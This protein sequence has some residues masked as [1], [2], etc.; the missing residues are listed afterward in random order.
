MQLKKCLKKRYILSLFVFLLL[1]F[2]NIFT[3]G[4]FLIDEKQSNKL[5]KNSNN[6]LDQNGKNNE[7]YDGN[8]IGSWGK[9]KNYSDGNIF[10]QINQGRNSKTGSFM[11][12]WNSLND[13]SSGT[14]TGFFRNH[15]LIGKIQNNN[16]EKP[17]CFIGIINLYENDFKAVILGLKIG[18]VYVSGEHKTSF[19]PPLTGP[20][21]VGVKSIHLIDESRLEEFTPDNPNDFREV[22][23]Q[24]WY[25]IDKEI[26][27]PRADYMD[28]PTFAWLK[29]KSPIPLF[30]IPNNAYLF[31]RPH[32]KIQVPISTNE[33]MY[34]VIIF[35][36]GY[37][38]V[39][40]IYTSLIEDIVSNG[41]IIASINHPYVSGITVFPDGRKIYISPDPP[42][43]YSLRSI[44]E[45]A[46]FI[47]DKITEMNN[48]DPDFQGKFDLSKVGMYGHSYGGASTSICCY[49]DERFLC[50]LTLDGVFYFDYLQ[51]GINKP[52]LML[53]AENRFNDDSVKKMWNKLNNDA[54]KVQINGSTHFAFTDVGVLLKHLVPLIPAKLLGF[55]T[56][57]PKHHV[58]IT[59]IFELM[60]FEVYL[61][62]RSAEDIIK[63]GTI[64]ND[65]QI[66]YKN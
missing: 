22:M 56:I 12:E 11:G 66:E 7:W 23:V 15:L 13:N 1:F 38:G 33:D 29:N 57:E 4:S 62:D 9:N 3:A 58:N 65:V 31:V 55:G 2:S 21:G 59:R 41:F 50:G 16:D 8:F 20:Y 53:I 45:D 17:A 48:S 51:E 5:N 28:A 25:P 36:P 61:K 49:E 52:F 54:Y 35:S 60:F 6:F 24:L 42:G 37:D 26:L 10:G 27:E 14:F 18:I 19:L 32:G 30:T 39:Y 64:F 44:V 40:Q 63:L 34:P 46:K 43:N 47:L